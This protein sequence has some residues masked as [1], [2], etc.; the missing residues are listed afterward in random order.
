MEYINTAKMT[1]QEVIKAVQETSSIEALRKLAKD[2]EVPFSGN[3]GLETLR[4][5]IVARLSQFVSASPDNQGQFDEP[6]LSADLEDDEPIQVNQPVKVSKPKLDLLSMDPTT[7]EDVSLRRQVIRAQALRL[8]RVKIQNLDPGDAVLSGGIISLQNKYTGKV[9]KYIPYG[10]ESENGYHI[11]W[12]I[13]EHLKQ[14]RF[15]L[16]KEQKG[17][18]FGVKT[19]KT[20][21][22]PKF[23]VELLPALTL[24][25]LK[26]L[27]NHQRASQ[28]LDTNH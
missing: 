23:S 22:V 16:R 3:T 24:S 25:E 14:W 7:I 8:V 20:V 11:P 2:M 27:A 9:A 6:D 19:Y 10:E 26:E 17:G 4:N 18:R 5:K 1:A 12:M 13:Y 15:P 28:S 21:M